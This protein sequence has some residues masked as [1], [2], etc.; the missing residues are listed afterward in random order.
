LRVTDEKGSKAH[1]VWDVILHEDWDHQSADDDA[2][3]ALIVLEAEVDLIQQNVGLVSLPPPSEGKVIGTGYVVGWDINE[4][5][6]ASTPNELRLLAVTQLQCFEADQLL[7]LVSS[8]RTFCAGFVNESNS[9]CKGDSGGGYFLVDQSTGTSNLVGIA[10][11]P[12][13][14]SSCQSNTFSIFTDVSKFTVWIE[15][16]MEETKQ[17]KWEEVEFECID[18]SVW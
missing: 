11:V 16:K 4:R 17:I 10:S 9:S 12:I 1:A 7:S 13:S 2:D 6:S 14:N 5:S 3:I 8:N 18:I 15:E